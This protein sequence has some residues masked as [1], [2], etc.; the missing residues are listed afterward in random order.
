VRS[1]A[2]GAAA[3]RGRAGATV[4]DLLDLFGTELG[5][6][7]PPLHL[8]HGAQLLHLRAGVYCGRAALISGRRLNIVGTGAASVISGSDA[9]C[10]PPSPATAA[11]AAGR[12]LDAAPDVPFTLVDAEATFTAV[13]FEG[14]A[15]AVGALVSLVRSNVSFVRCAFRGGAADAD[16]GAV[17]I[18]GASNVTLTDCTVS[19]CTA[20]GRG[21]AV[22]ADDSAAVSITGCTFDGC[23]AADGGALWAGAG[24]AVTVVDSSFTGNAASGSGGA[25]HAA[26]GA[27][28]SM[29]GGVHAGCTAVFG[30]F[31][32]VARGAALT[33]AGG[34]HSRHVASLG[35]SDDYATS[36]GGA[37][38]L[39]RVEG[40]LALVGG[41]VSRCEAGDGGAVSA[42]GGGAAA[43]LT[44][45]AFSTNV[46]YATGGTVS[47]TGGATL[48]MNACAVRRSTISDGNGIGGA[49]HCE[50]SALALIATTIVGDES[51][52]PVSSPY[53]WYFQ[54]YDADARGGGGI[55]ATARCSLTLLD[56]DLGSLLALEGGGLLVQDSTANLTRSRV[57]HSSGGC[58][59]ASGSVLTLSFCEVAFGYSS[60]GAAGL[61][62]TTGSTTI[63]DSS[64]TDNYSLGAGGGLAFEVWAEFWVR[65][66]LIARN[67]CAEGCGLLVQNDAVTKGVERVLIRGNAAATTGGG[68]MFRNLLQTAAY[69]RDCVITGNTAGSSGGGIGLQGQANVYLERVTISDNAAACTPAGAG[70]GVMLDT[71]LTPLRLVRC[72]LVRN[73]ACSGGAIGLGTQRDTDLVLENAVVEYNSATAGSGGAIGN[74]V[75][76]NRVGFTLAVS[77]GSMMFNAASAD[78]GAVA[79]SGPAVALSLRVSNV[80]VSHNRAGGNGGLLALRCAPACDAAFQNVTA[81]NVTADGRG[82]VLFVHDARHVALTSSRVLQPAAAFALIFRRTGSSA[83]VSV[84]GTVLDTSSCV[85]FGGQSIAAVVTSGAR[86]AQSGLPLSPSIRIAVLDEYNNTNVVDSGTVCAASASDGAVLG[87]PQL[88][89]RGAVVLPDVAVRGPVGSVV[90][91]RL[92]CTLNDGLASPAG[93]AAPFALPTLHI[94]ILP[95]APGSA[96]NAGG[97]CEACHVG[98]YSPAGVSCVSCPESASC[99]SSSSSGGGDGGSSAAATGP[100]V[101]T[102]LPA[103]LP[104]YW[105]GAT[106]TSLLLGTCAEMSAARGGCAPGSYATARGTCEAG[107]GRFSLDDVYACSGGGAQLYPCRAPGA[108]RGGAT[109]AS[110]AS[111]GGA[112]SQCAEGAYGPLCDL[113]AE[114]YNRGADGSCAPCARGGETAAAASARTAGL[115]ALGGAFCV[116]AFC[117][118]ACGVQHLAA[119][120]PRDM[121]RRRRRRSDGATAAAAQTGAAGASLR[122]PSQQ[123][124][125]LVARALA[126][127]RRARGRLVFPSE[128]LKLVVTFVQVSARRCPELQHHRR[129]HVCCVTSIFC[130]CICIYLYLRPWCS[131]SPVLSD[132]SGNTQ[133]NSTAV[134]VCARRCSPGSNRRCT[135][136]SRRS[137]SARSVPSPSSTSTSWG[138][139]PWAASRPRASTPRSSRR[140]RRRSWRRRCSRAR[141]SPAARRC[142]GACATAPSRPARA[143]RTAR[144]VASR[145][146]R[147]A[148]SRSWSR[149]AA[150]GAAGRPWALQHPRRMPLHA[151]APRCVTRQPRAPRRQQRSRAAPRRGSG[152]V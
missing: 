78:G 38:G 11:A 106:S 85:A 139:P 74:I 138:P 33:L 105:L 14:G 26:A 116:A 57:H 150:A 144:T 6:S 71:S 9:A 83:S 86:A 15:A 136:P 18:T 52:T 129:R 104:G 91:V 53:D 151:H 94:G 29:S 64:I 12:R 145:P 103:S 37:G 43:T 132:N 24:V 77:G 21:G 125:S 30:G 1:S 13:A 63:E 40:T 82:A 62:A 114:G 45:V 130:I 42:A 141:T 147:C 28:V 98:E 122:R 68:V 54:P 19:G 76:P 120:C 118:A 119:A 100:A 96:Q 87:T 72:V 48:L 131:A 4:S 143:A 102:A 146:C 35:Q 128:K 101:G 20:G 80:D 27:L 39:V 67:T 142:G 7:G 124:R 121:C 70:G 108:C 95:C 111:G 36:A 126:W 60:V 47:A 17:A 3:D 66:S 140:R 10:G 32:Y 79:L 92:T 84:T 56:S 73:R 58:I 50:A 44:R 16:G 127:A 137:C 5:G 135:C 148:S 97:A 117:V 23:S 8:E 34:A 75:V 22:F 41:S 90:V 55:S 134:W 69:M 46:A 109:A 31:A 112:G 2:R 59:A 133:V 107:S 61:H 115:I 152:A 49:A 81:R 99:S 65:R 93:A 110:N 149:R 88:A 89:L 113:C 123:R 25:L 51:R